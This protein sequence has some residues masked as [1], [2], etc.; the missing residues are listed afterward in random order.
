MRKQFVETGEFYLFRRS[1]ISQQDFIFG[2]KKMIDGSNI[3]DIHTHA[4]YEIAKK[5][6]K[7]LWLF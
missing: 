7:D 6:W 4:D 1:V 5:L 2:R 3:M